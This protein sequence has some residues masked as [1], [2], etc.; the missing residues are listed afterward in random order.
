MER[1]FSYVFHKPP[2]LTSS[3]KK[4]YANTNAPYA[5][6]YWKIHTE[7]FDTEPLEQLLSSLS[8]PTHIIWG[9]QDRV[10]HVSSIDK[11]TP[12]LS[13]VKT[14]I[15]DAVGHLPMLEKPQESAQLVSDFINNL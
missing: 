2:F 13:N 9:Q 4:H 7:F 6:L 15:L 1:F 10:L 8:V 11:M 3:I 12:L 14:T 5:D